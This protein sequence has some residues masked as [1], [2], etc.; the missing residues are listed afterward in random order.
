[1]SAA[2][3]RLVTVDIDGTLTRV[4]GWR[5]ISRAI[6]READFD[7]TNLRFFA[8]E[9]SEDEHLR[10][11]VGLAV[12]HSV[13]ELESIFEATPLV[14]DIASSV[15]A[16]HAQGAHVALLTHNPDYVCAWYRRTFGFDDA[17][18]MDGRW[19][20]DGVIIDPGPVRADKLTGLRRLEARW[21]VRPEEVAHVGDGWA[22]AALFPHVGAGIAFNSSF[23]D[24][25]RRAD[26]ALRSDTF[27]DVLP[28]LAR[29]TPKSV[30]EREPS[31]AHSS[32]TSSLV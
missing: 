22:D 27:A 21:N 12:R 26:A 7:A 30:V 29:L 9:I 8:H 32:N 1:M 18:G 10:N 19:V 24:V 31:P 25:E 17:E 15:V 11:L 4:H 28:V 16:L 23:P 14:A 20:R 3:Y 5:V 6:G 13:S 2:T